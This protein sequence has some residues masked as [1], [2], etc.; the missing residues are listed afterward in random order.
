M[1]GTS[2]AD[3]A[4]A[5]SLASSYVSC[6]PLGGRT[7]TFCTGTGPVAQPIR[8]LPNYDV[9]E[10]MTGRARGPNA[11]L[12][13]IVCVYHGTDQSK[14]LKIHRPSA[15]DASGSNLWNRIDHE[16]FPSRRQGCLS[17]PPGETRRVW[18]WRW[19]PTEGH[20]WIMFTP[21]SPPRDYTLNGHKCRPPADS[22]PAMLLWSLSDC[23]VKPRA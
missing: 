21:W 4:K 3:G 18:P 2:S 7:G 22:M 12:Q 6:D 11:F 17:P 15:L 8:F 5:L 23:L 1:P 13:T 16:E 19:A 14:E 10:R 20:E 9:C